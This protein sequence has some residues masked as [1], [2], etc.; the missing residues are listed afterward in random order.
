MML[1]VTGATGNVGRGVLP[2][3]LAAGHE[4]R[5]L[6]RSASKLAASA[7]CTPVAGDPLKR[8]DVIRALDG[9]DAVVHL[10]GTR[11]SQIKETGLGYEEVDVGSVRVMV[12]AMATAGVRRILLLSAGAIGNSTYVRSKAHAERLVIDAG[13]DWT[14]FRP[15][16][17]IGSGQQ[18]PLLMTPF[19]RLMGLM[20]GKI[21]DVGR[22]AGNVTL[23]ELGRSMA[24]ALATPSAIG[25]TL[26]VPEIRRTGRP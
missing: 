26:D 22:R 15:A 11:R 18:W 21:G 1:C 25:A 3:L 2:V 12:E 20:P 8:D 17:I 10:I 7:A 4:A 23:E 5:A 13:L 19:L 16:F 24:W 9:C 14:I 6:V